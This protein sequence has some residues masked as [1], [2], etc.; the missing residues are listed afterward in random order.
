[1]ARESAATVEAVISRF[2]GDELDSVTAAAELGVESGQRESCAK[3]LEVL[4]EEFEIIR[5]LLTEA[6]G[7][8]LLL[9]HESPFHVDFDYH[10]FADGLQ[11]RLHRGSI[12][13]K[14]AIA[15]TGPDIVF[16]G[17]MHTEGRDVIETVD[18]YANL[19]NSGSPG[20]AI[21]EIDTTTGSLQMQT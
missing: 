3:N 7:T 19:Y 16:S 8:T 4:A 10:H 20:V 5:S 21:V 2:L 1:M 9:S 13:L 11:Q 15:V 6:T 18:G 14:M 12:P 17:H